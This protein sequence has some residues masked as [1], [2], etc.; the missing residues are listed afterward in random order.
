MAA[1]ISSITPSLPSLPS[2]SG[3]GQAQPTNGEG[4]FSKLLGNSIDSLEQ[5][6]RAAETAQ[7]DL[8]T[9]KTTDVTS[10][11]L[12]TEKATMNLQLAT[13]V[14]TRIV[15]AYVEIMRTQV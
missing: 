8:A 4:G 13:Q 2:L 11:V 6:Q 10:V 3:I 5:S 1:P 7:L 9:G 15:D 12:A 14:R